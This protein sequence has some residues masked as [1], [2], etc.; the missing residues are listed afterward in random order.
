[1]TTVPESLEEIIVTRC[2]WTGCIRHADCQ[3]A[4]RSALNAPPGNSRGHVRWV[5]SDRLCRSHGNQQVEH[6]TNL[7]YEGAHLLDL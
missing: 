4:Y 7:G 1:M 6:V 2:E 5:L 3:M